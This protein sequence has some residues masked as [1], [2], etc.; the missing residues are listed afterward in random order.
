M[1]WLLAL[2]GAASTLDTAFWQFKRY[3][4]PVMA[5]LFPAAAWTCAALA[6]RFAERGWLSWTRWI[7]PLAILLPAGLTTVTFARNYAENVQVVRDQQVPMA[8]WAAEHLP[9][10][11]RVGVHDVGLMGYFSGLPLYDVVGLTT[12]GPAESWRQDLARF[13]STW[14]RANTGQS[15]SRFIPTCRG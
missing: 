9:E 11:V 6:D 7:L 13:S 10:G 1:L 12:P 5:L 4:V 3:Q 8:R 14:R 15:I 2:T